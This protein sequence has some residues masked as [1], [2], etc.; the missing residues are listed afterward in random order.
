MNV[1]Y[2]PARRLIESHDEALAEKYGL[3][4]PAWHADL[5]IDPTEPGF[6]IRP[7][8]FECALASG[9]ARLVIFPEPVPDG[10]YSIAVTLRFADR[11]IVTDVPFRLCTH[12][13]PITSMTFIASPRR[14][15]LR[16][17]FGGGRYWDGQWELPDSGKFE[18]GS[19]MMGPTGLLVSA[20][21]YAGIDHDMGE[22]PKA[23]ACRYAG[24]GSPESRGRDKSQAE[25]GRLDQ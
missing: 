7:A 3:Y 22:G 8:H 23:E 6:G 1:A 5:G 12:G 14:L 2:Q 9:Q 21:N 17:R 19:A 20:I 13:G 24:P 16:G 25:Q 18:V 15:V 4:V 10:S 11:L